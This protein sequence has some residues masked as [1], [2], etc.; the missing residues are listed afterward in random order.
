MNNLNS[1][2]I[3]GTLVRE[4]TYKETANVCTF[5]IASSRFYKNGGGLEEEVSFF[6]VEA[7]GKLAGNCYDLGRKGRGV[8]VVGRLRQDRWTDDEGKVRSRV[9]IVAEHVEFRPDFSG[10]DTLFPGGDFL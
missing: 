9:S 7:Q 3:E 1:V 5:G 6:D 4:P 10:G 8:R 2:L